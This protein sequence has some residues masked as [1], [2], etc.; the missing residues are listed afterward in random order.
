MKRHV[1]TPPRS[2]HAFVLGVLFLLFFSATSIQAQGYACH[3]LVV[4]ITTTDPGASVSDVSCNHGDE[5]STSDFSGNSLAAIVVVDQSAVYGP[6]C[7]ITVTG[8]NEVTAELAVQ[9][10]FC[11]LEAG[12]VTGS[13]SS[14]PAYLLQTLEGSYITA[15]PGV[16]VFSFVPPGSSFATDEMR[17]KVIGNARVQ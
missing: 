2:S 8:S 13:V 12:R 7:T 4:V 5:V 16:L 17:D 15:W 10:N 14:G 1:E 3:N 11:A 9:Q 6:N